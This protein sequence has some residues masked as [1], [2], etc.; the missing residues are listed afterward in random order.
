[1]YVTWRYGDGEGA[2]FFLLAKF[3]QRANFF[4]LWPIFGE[5]WTQKKHS[6]RQKFIHFDYFHPFEPIF[7]PLLGLSSNIRMNWLQD[8]F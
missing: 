2:A 3:C 4:Y 6:G 8:M 1:M 5:I 7:Y